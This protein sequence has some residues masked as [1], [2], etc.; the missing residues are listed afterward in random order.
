MCPY[1][2]CSPVQFQQ[3][4]EFQWIPSVELELIVCFNGMNNALKICYIM[5]AAFV[6]LNYYSSMH[7]WMKSFPT[8]SQMG[9]VDCQYGVV[10]QVV[11]QCMLRMCS[12]HV[13][14]QVVSIIPAHLSSSTRSCR[15]SGSL[16]M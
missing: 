13:H 4:L 15:Y 11:I 8:A 1:N 16:L 6:V 9:I 14:R 2:T 12:F 10:M 5:Q 3:V 7:S